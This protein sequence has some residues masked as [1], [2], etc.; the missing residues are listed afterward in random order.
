MTALI[1]LRTSNGARVLDA[2]RD[3]P[4]YD[5]RGASKALSIALDRIADACGLTPAGVW[6]ALRSRP[7]Q[8]VSAGPESP[9]FAENQL[10]MRLATMRGEAIDR[11][12]EIAKELAKARVAASQF[13]ERKAAVR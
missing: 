4:G 1:L 10:A 6:H 12:T 5:G 7:M 9:T 8:T 2:P 3:F 13:S 11:A